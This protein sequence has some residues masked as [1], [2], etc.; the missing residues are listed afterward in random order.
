M[1]IKKSIGERLFNV[2]NVLF[3]LALM[4]VMAVPLWHVLMASLSDSGE[5]VRAAGEG[6]MLWPRGF[7]FDAYRLVAKNPNIFNGYKIT[8]LV[9]V[10][11]TLMSV[12]I[13]SFGAYAL[14]RKNLMW[15]GLVNRMIVFTMLFSGGLIPTYIII[16]N[17]YHLGNNLLVL[18]LPGIVSQWNLM[19]M[20]TSF[21]GIPES[22]IE[23]AKI[24]GANDFTIL[25]K[26]VYPTSMAIIVVMILFYGIG[27]WNAWFNAML[28]IRNRSLFP[29]QLILREILLQN[30]TNAMTTD[31]ALSDK[32]SVS[33]SIKYALIVVSTLPI[34]CLYPFLQKYFVKGVMIGAVKG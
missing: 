28:Y 4:F 31:I 25:F 16:N 20:R 33:E 14:S 11:G 1:L 15:K 5:I 23:S 30:S 2:F 27:Y 21:E 22:L 26:I 17:V 24:D 34:L 9:V 3:M 13:T 32:G 18:I 8:I 6:V 29:L 12:V 7:N 10:A 19:V